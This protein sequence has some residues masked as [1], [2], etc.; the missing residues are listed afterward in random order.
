VPHRVIALRSRR[1]AFRGRATPAWQAE[2]ARAADCFVRVRGEAPPGWK[3]DQLDAVV[4]DSATWNG[5]DLTDAAR[6]QFRAFLDKFP[7][8]NHG[9]YPYPV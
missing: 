9:T 1:R 3:V 5:P 6:A 7:V 2:G 4:K 8:M